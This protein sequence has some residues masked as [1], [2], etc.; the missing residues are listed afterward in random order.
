[1]VSRTTTV[2]GALEEC[3]CV[4]W[5]AESAACGLG[6]DGSGTDWAAETAVQI[7]QQR[8]LRADWAPEHELG[9]GG[10]WR[11][12]RRAQRRR[13]QTWR[14]NEVNGRACDSRL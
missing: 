14:D 9:S 5:A 6:N 12:R 10:M 4:D 3:D 8:R 11:Q 7:G 2:A 1:V 13:R